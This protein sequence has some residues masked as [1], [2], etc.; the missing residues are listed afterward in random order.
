[1]PTPEQVLEALQLD[2]VHRVV[3]AWQL[4]GSPPVQ[5]SSWVRTSTQNAA[6]GG[7]PFSQHLLGLALDFVGPY[8]RFADQLE[9]QGL[10]VVREGD[11]LH[12]QRLPAGLANDIGL[13]DV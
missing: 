10:T 2:T 12:V 7:A 3:R 4:A 9:A 8:D 6:V 13:F 5:I 11:H 1:M